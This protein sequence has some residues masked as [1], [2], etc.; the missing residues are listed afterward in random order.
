MSVRVEPAG[1]G[2]TRQRPEL[3]ERLRAEGLTPH[4]WGNG[5]GDRYGWHRHDYHKVLCCVSGS[6]VFH[7]REGD[8]ELH[9]GDRLDVEPGTDHA[10][11]VG[12]DGVECIE[13]A[14]PA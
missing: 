12:P 6:I 8:I 2:E 10:A 13:A 5:P 7:T 14:R 4:A 11:T 9:Q 1:D 3:E